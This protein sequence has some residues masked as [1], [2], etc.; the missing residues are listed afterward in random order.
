MSSDRQHGADSGNLTADRKWVGSWAT[1]P[2][3]QTTLV[4]SLP[5]N[6]TIQTRIKLSCGGTA[7]RLSFTNLSNDRDLRLGAVT[8]W[9]ERAEEESVALPVHF[10]DQETYTLAHGRT[11]VSD[12]IQGSFGPHTQIIVSIYLPEGAPDVSGGL[13]GF[14]ALLSPPGDWTRQMRFCGNPIKVGAFSASPAL[15]VT[16]ASVLASADA[17]VAAFFGDSNTRLYAGYLI[18]H[19]MQFQSPDDDLAILN[20]GLDGN[21]LLRDGV[22]LGSP[23]GVGA[24][25]FFGGAAAV[26]RFSDTLAMLSRGDVVVIMSGEGDLILPGVMS[27]SDESVTADEIIAG[28]DGCIS[29]GQQ[30]GNRLVG[31]TILPFRTWLPPGG[32]P[33]G[34][35]WSDFEER[36]KKRLRVNRWITD[37]A[38]FDAVVDAA[39]LLADAADSSCLAA[40]YDAGDHLHLNAMGCRKLAEAVV[41][42]IDDVLQTN[43]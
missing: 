6:L 27:P 33:G 37:A 42:T 3:L 8:A 39:V 22:S 24:A 14:E 15:F 29:A 17:R 12:C 16:S 26:R 40:E 21:R 19:L 2:W 38:P 23:K 10:D 34:V 4:G 7:L 5:P 9:I 41:T 20:F 43:A 32:W 28:L 11:K 31:A 30:R 18:E 35:R 13:H 25:G 1:A 36:E